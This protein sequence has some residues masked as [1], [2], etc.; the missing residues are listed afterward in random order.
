LQRDFRINPAHNQKKAAQ[1][2]P[3]HADTD[4]GEDMPTAD[5]AEAA[6]EDDRFSG[7]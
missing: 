2:E 3:P 1:E 4:E 5:G 6:G 7:D